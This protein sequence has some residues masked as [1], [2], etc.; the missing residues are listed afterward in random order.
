MTRNR[1]KFGSSK[2]GWATTVWVDPGGN[3]GWGV[4]SVNPTDLLT[5]KPVEKI[6]QHWACDET[7]KKNENQMASE[8][9]ELYDMWEDAAIGIESF[10]IRK[11]LQHHEFLS[12]VRIRSKIEY[13]LWLMEKWDAEENDRPMGR[14]RHLFR[15]TP[16]QAKSTLT[17]DRQRAAG[18]WVPGLDHKRDG[19]KH[20]YTFLT[21]AQAIPRLRGVAWPHLFKQ[22]GSLLQRRAPTTKRGKY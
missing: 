19:I 18:L 12:P 20:C 5:S 11:F 22:D 1:V 4:M 8:M 7:G 15:Q 21:R 10:T 2:T 6:I 16:A 13:A 9:L 14:G 17:D 3:T